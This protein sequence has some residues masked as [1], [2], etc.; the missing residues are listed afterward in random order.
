M[1]SWIDITTV[2][3]FQLYPC[4]F[5]KVSEF[6]KVSF[7]YVKDTFKSKL[8]RLIHECTFVCRIKLVLLLFFYYGQKEIKQH[9]SYFNEDRKKNILWKSFTKC[10]CFE[11]KILVIIVKYTGRL[12]KNIRV[13][14]NWGWKKTL[15]CYTRS[16]CTIELIRYTFSWYPFNPIKYKSGV[17]QSISSSVLCVIYG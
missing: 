16:I 2:A 4:Y 3:L 8:P 7:N 17:M 13:V 6:S 5:G 15:F 11:Q 10:W 12:Y 9:H 14:S 1:V